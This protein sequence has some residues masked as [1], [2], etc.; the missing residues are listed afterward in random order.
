M[1]I[2]MA[3]IIACLAASS[4]FLLNR[5]LLKLLGVQTIIT[6]SPVLEEMVKTLSAYYF[7]ADIL[8]THGV[9]GLIEAVYDWM[10]TRGR[11]LAAVLSIVGH[12]LFGFVTVFTAQLTGVYIGLAAGIVTHLLWNTIMV[13]FCLRGAR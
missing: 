6:L 9:F 2:K 4:S 1:K 11:L 13:R 5:A 10:Q 8:V 12:S 3:Y 7:D